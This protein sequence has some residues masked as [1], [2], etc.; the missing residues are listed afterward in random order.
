MRAIRARIALSPAT[1]EWLNAVC[2]VR[3]LNLDDSKCQASYY[4]HR[5]AFIRRFDMASLRS[6]KRLCAVARRAFRKPERRQGG[7]TTA[8]NHQLQSPRRALEHISDMEHLRTT[9][10]RDPG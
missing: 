9:Y 6:Q 5:A 4:S 7:L 3:T 10:G 1:H 2:S 8:R